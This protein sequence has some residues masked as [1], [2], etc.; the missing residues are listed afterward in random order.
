MHSFIQNH[1]DLLGHTVLD[2][3][4]NE[5]GVQLLSSPKTEGISQNLGN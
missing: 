4:G 2:H 5:T 3:S 1:V